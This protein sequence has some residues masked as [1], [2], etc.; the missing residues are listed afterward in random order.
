[1]REVEIPDETEVDIFD[2]MA[3]A[4][5]PLAV[6]VADTYPLIRRSLP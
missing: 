4:D 6:Q 5:D 2:L 1:V 3:L